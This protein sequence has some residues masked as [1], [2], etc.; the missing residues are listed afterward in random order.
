MKVFLAGVSHWHAGMHLDAARAAGAEIVGAWD[1]E[2]SHAETFAARNELTP[3]VEFDRVLDGSPDLIVL[4]GHPSTIPARAR[5]IIEA[6]IPMMLEKPAASRTDQLVELREIARQCGAFVSVPLPN[7]YG[8][9]VTA[10]EALVH[11]GRAGKLAHCHF[12]IVNGPP[13]RYAADGVA[14]V[15]DP[16]VGGGGALRNLGIHGIDA[17]LSLAT[18]RLTIKSALVENRIHD[19]PVEDYALLVLKDE[20][21]AIFT[22]EAG[23]TFASMKPGG[24]FEWRIVSANATLI[25]HGDRAISATLDDGKLI[26]LPVEPPSIRYRLCMRVTLERLRRGAPPAISLDDY[27]AAMSLIDK[28]YE[29]AGR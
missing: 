15:V 4:M 12:R 25:D 10:Y 1:E 21:G 2:A 3:F 20:V 11:E 28:A 17:A 9:A 18:G 27:V 16:A 8:P 7:R 5:R 19:S 24:D 29:L 6:G 14:W 22:V 23:Y 26:D 13:A